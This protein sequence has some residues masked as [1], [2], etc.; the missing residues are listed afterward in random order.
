MLAERPSSD[1]SAF[2]LE[3][4]ARIDKL[5]VGGNVAGRDVVIGV[6]P[7]D[8]EKVTDRQQVLELL[9]RLEAEVAKLEEAPSGLRDDAADELRKAKQAGRE[10]DTQRLAEKLETA[11]GYLE[12]ITATLPAALSLAQAVAM[13]AQRIPGLT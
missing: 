2:H 8:A 3:R 12:R 5:S 9:E 1:S 10:G 4:G 6:T 7:S 13:L 11:H